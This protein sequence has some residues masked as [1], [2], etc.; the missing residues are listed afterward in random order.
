MCV[1]LYFLKNMA[2]VSTREPLNFEKMN[3]VLDLIN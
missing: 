2:A 1:P 3:S